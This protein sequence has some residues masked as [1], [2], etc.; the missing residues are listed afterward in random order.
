MSILQTPYQDFNHFLLIFIRVGVILFLLPFFNSRKIQVMSKVGMS[1]G[2]TILLYPVI[3]VLGT[4]AMPA[5]TLG[6]SRLIAGEL[7]IGMILGLMVQVFFE[8]VKIMGEMVGFQTGLSIANIIDP[9]SGTQVPIFSNMAYL[10]AMILFLLLNGHHILL[11]A[12]RGSFEIIQVGSLSLNPLLMQKMISHVGQMFV[13]GIKIG[14]PA[15]AAL[16][17]TKIV[18]GLITKFIPQM[19]IMIV[20]FPAQIAIGLLF[21]G[22]SLRLVLVFIE[23]YVDHLETI[24]ITTMKW[25]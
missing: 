19:N 21:F 4:T 3:D 15:I 16:L 7:I 2:I 22:I 23:E 25:I 18:F 20:A 10:L 17:F 1:F 9:Q 8:G 11:N 13:I 6:I 12:L 24:M 14:A 5:T